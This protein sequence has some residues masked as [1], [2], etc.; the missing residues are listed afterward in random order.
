MRSRFEERL[1][2]VKIAAM[3][4]TFRRYGLEDLFRDRAHTPTAPGA[5]NKVVGAGLGIGDFFRDMHLGS[6]VSLFEALQAQY[7]KTKSVPKALGNYLKGAYTGPGILPKV[8]AI[9]LPAAFLGANVLSASEEERP[10]ALLRGGVGLVASPFVGR[11]GDVG[12][13]LLSEPVKARATT[14]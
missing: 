9:G 11:L 8:V 12:M 14:D 5:Y 4:R 13:E 3:S 7:K 1:D 6:P 10:A 2:G